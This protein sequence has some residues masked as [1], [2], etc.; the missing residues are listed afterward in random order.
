MKKFAVLG[1][2]VGLGMAPLAHATTIYNTVQPFTGDWS[3]FG[4][5]DT[6]TYGQTFTVGSDHVLNS[7]SLFLDGTPTA[8]FNFEAYVYAWNGAE[9]TGPALY[10]S[11]LQTFS[12]TPSG[13]PQEFAFNVGA[14]NLTSGNQYVAFLSTAGVQDGGNN[15]AL[16][17]YSGTFGTDVLPDG[18]FVYYNTGNDFAA[19]TSSAWDLNSSNSCCGDVWFKATFSDGAVPEPASWAMMVLGFG[20]VGALLRRRQEAPL[21]V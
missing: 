9:A 3:I 2:L 15:Y 20:A 14:I 11:S 16:M 19:L 13:N 10:T 17:P 5:P 4:E 6:S 8:S 7:F 18:Q 1:L 21:A 12:G